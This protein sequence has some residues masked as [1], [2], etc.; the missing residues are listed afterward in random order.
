MIQ[1]YEFI[2]SSE[3]QTLNSELTYYR[4]K[5]TDFDGKFSYSNII[6]VRIISD[7]GIIIQANSSKGQL[8][9]SF[10]EN[11][12]N[13]NC[14]VK[15]YDMSG[16]V[17]YSSSFIPNKSKKEMWIDCSDWNNG[18]YIIS[19]NSENGISSQQKFIK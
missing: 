11:Y 13:K 2:R 3:L 17:C 9:V 1:N 18:I 14:A 19:A 12:E 16:R 6:S 5:Q 7:D 4:L 15:I 10:S 8:F